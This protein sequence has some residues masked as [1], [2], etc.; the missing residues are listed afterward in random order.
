MS[1][2]IVRS[3]SQKKLLRVVIRY[4]I[5]WRI[6]VIG[7]SDNRSAG[8]LTVVDKKWSVSYLTIMQPELS[9]GGRRCIKAWHYLGVTRSFVQGDVSR[10][11]FLVFV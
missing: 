7:N 5:I 11:R 8:F 10:M 4:F 1:L 6:N 9:A 3:H 2:G